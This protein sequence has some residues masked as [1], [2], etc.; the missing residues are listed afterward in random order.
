MNASVQHKWHIR[1]LVFGPME[2][3]EKPAPAKAERARAFAINAPV[4]V[5]SLFLPFIGNFIFHIG[6]AQL[7]PHDYRAVVIGRAEHVD[8]H[9]CGSGRPSIGI[10]PAVNGAHCSKC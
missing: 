9:G 7:C 10:A 1:P 8:V 2:Y 4:K 6:L 3:A 5:E